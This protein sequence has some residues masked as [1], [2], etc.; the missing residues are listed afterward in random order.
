MIKYHIK[1]VLLNMRS[2]CYCDI[3]E[4]QGFSCEPITE[5]VNGEYVQAENRRFRFVKENNS[6]TDRITFEGQEIKG[7][8]TA[9]DIAHCELKK[10]VIYIDRTGEH[11]PKD[12]GSSQR[13]HRERSLAHDSRKKGH[14]EHQKKK[15]KR[16]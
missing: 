8:L 10:R 16:Y 11:K 13:G 5:Q 7:G 6:I 15:N 12:G 14:K 9:N 4:T 3:N 2:E 1:V